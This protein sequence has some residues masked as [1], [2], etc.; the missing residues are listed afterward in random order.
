MIT[1]WCAV[2]VSLPLVIAGA[3][4]LV[5][6]W[7]T[8]AGVIIA[9]SVLSS[10]VVVLNCAAAKVGHSESV[11]DLL[12]A[13]DSRGYANA[14]VFTR[15]GYDRTAEFYASGRVV[16]GSDNDV[17]ELDEAAQ[18][19]IEVNKRQGPILVLVPIENLGQLKGTPAD[20]KVLLAPYGTSPGAVMEVIGTNG[21]IALV[22]VKPGL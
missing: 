17:E 14:T 22:G 10:L 2:L 4:S 21:R 8:N 12:Q 9:G 18:L 15:R 20:G 5:S 3:C 11:R 13:A 16:Y 19:L 7:R 6:R 1:I